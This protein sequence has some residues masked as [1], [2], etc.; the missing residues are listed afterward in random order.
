MKLGDTARLKFLLDD[1][2]DLSRRQWMKK[3]IK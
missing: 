1:F 3:Y 2:K